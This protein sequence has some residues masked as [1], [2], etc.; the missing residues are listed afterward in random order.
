VALPLFL[1]MIDGQQTFF[2]NPNSYPVADRGVG[3][4]MAFFCPKHNG[5]G[6]FYLM[7]IKDQ[8]GPLLESK[9]TY[10]VTVPPDAPVKQYWS[11]TAYDRATP[12]NAASPRFP[13]S[14]APSAT[15]SST[16][17]SRGSGSRADRP[18]HPRCSDAAK[19]SLAGDLRGCF[20]KNQPG[21]SA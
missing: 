8:E 15:S 12:R 6:S 3:Y 14:S 19:R 7:A 21:R 1:E 2:A 17:R 13:C 18:Y 20:D 10:Q 4:S 16:S 11:A 9:S 5:A